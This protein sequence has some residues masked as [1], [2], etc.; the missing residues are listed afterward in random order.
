MAS[1]LFQLQTGLLWFVNCKLRAWQDSDSFQPPSHKCMR[2]DEFAM[3]AML[4][5]C[6]SV[7]LQASLSG[8]RHEPMNIASMI[9][10]VIHYAAVSEVLNKI[11]SV[12]SYPGRCCEHMCPHLSPRPSTLAFHR[13]PTRQFNNSYACKQMQ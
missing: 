13:S 9:R 2:P 7:K 5:S 11:V 6:G 3:Y 12:L 10:L 4:W 8:T 1:T